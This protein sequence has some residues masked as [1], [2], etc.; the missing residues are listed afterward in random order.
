MN[1]IATLQQ[2]SRLLYLYPDGTMIPM[3]A[4]GHDTGQPHTH[5]APP[6][7][8]DDSTS[9]SLDALIGMTLIDAMTGQGGTLMKQRGPGDPRR[10]QWIYYLQAP[11]QNPLRINQG[12]I[13]VDPLRNSFSVLGG[14]LFRTT[15]KLSDDD[16]RSLFGDSGLGGST[17]LGRDQAAQDLDRAQIEHLRQQEAIAREQLAADERAQ[18]L[19]RLTDLANAATGERANRERQFNELQGDPFRFAAGI[20]RRALSGQT[21]YQAWGSFLQT[22]LAKPPPQIDFNAPTPVLQQQVNAL[23]GTLSG[24]Q[25]VAPRPLS[26]FAEGG[27]IDGSGISFGSDWDAVLVGDARPNGDEEVLLKNRLTN[28]VM[29]VPLTG[30]AA[31]G[32][33]MPSTPPP[34]SVPYNR[35]TL[36]PAIAPFYNYLGFTGGI[37]RGNTASPEDFERLG[38]VKPIENQPEVGS[39][40][41]PPYG[42]LSEAYFEPETGAVLPNPTRISSLLRQY[43]DT[44]PAF[45]DLYVSAMSR[46]MAPDGSPSGMNR[47][48]IDAILDATALKGSNQAIIGV[49]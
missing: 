21:P 38:Y 26:G 4:G 14:G 41:P 17:A 6:P 37:P 5:T 18:V 46:A 2:G 1:A 44:N 3:I 16:V 25:P 7:E 27:K 30:H 11:G 28:D 39:F 23:Q 47:A 13:L 32:A 22:E 19:A 24:P 48:Y 49:R 35:D 31:Q 8:G 33:Y 9:N 45:Y 29:V 40:R 10:A 36:L 42:A 34:E 12:T 20:S 15:G 43:R